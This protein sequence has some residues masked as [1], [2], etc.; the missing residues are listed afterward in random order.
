[1]IALYYELQRRMAEVKVCGPRFH[2]EGQRAKTETS[3]SGGNARGTSATI[4]GWLGSDRRNYIYYYTL[5]NGW[6]S[7][8]VV[9]QGANAEFPPRPA[10]A[11]KLRTLSAG[12]GVGGRESIRRGEWHTALGNLKE[13]LNQMVVTYVDAKEGGGEDDGRAGY[14]N[15]SITVSSSLGTRFTYLRLG[16]ASYSSAM[17]SSGV[18]FLTDRNCKLLHVAKY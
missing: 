7:R 2:V 13:P 15:G 8:G 5:S 6:L 10:T 9:S 12:C 3:A 14:S 1:L 18:S 16:S 11:G 17:I 4:A